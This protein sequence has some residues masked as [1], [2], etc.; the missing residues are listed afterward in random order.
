MH[1]PLIENPN[2]DRDLGVLM[3]SEMNRFMESKKSFAY[4][5]ERLPQEEGKG[6]FLISR[7]VDKYASDTPPQALLDDVF[8]EMESQFNVKLSAC[9]IEGVIRAEALPYSPQTPDEVFAYLQ[10]PAIQENIQERELQNRTSLEGLIAE[11]APL[12]PI[13]HGWIAGFHFHGEDR[14][15]LSGTYGMEKR[16][17][18]EDGGS[19]YLVD[20]QSYIP[21]FRKAEDHSWIQRAI[22]HRPETLNGGSIYSQNIPDI[23]AENYIANLEK[24]LGEKMDDMTPQ[25]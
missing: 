10:S 6:T 23:T 4:T 19:Y 24:I 5:F 14:P 17:I 22:V 13:R 12:T 15:E 8:K 20:G 11:F 18:R 2:K 21:G 3:V 1:I 9:S 25:G 16:H 7:K